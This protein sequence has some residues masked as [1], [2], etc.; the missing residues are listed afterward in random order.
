MTTTEEK[1]RITVDDLYRLELVQDPQISP[2]GAHIV[3]AQQWVQKKDEKKF[4]NLW[5]VASDGGEPRQYTSGDHRDS[6]PRWSPDGET[7]AFLSNREDEKQTQIYLIPF[8]GGEAR[9][10]TDLKGNIG[11]FSWSPDG[12]R[13]LLQF[14][15]KDAEALERE[16]DEQKKKLGIVARR[17][18]RADFRMDGEGYRPEERWHV[19]S[20]DVESG[21]ATQLT[22][23]EYDEHG[24]RWSPDGKE[25]AF[26]SNRSEQPDLTP[27]LD[28]VFVM[29]AEGGEPRRLPT[30]EGGKMGLRY[31]PDG[32]LLSYVGRDGTGNWWRHNQLWV[33]SADGAGEA[34]SLTDRETVHVSNSTIGDVADR[35]LTAP[36]WS[37]DGD[38]VY[39]QASEH[40]NTQLKFV[41]LEGQV[42]DVLA[43][44]GVFSNISLDADGRRLA[45]LYGTFEEPGQLW[46]SDAGG[47][48]RQQLTELNR[49]WL[50]EIEL[51]DVQSVWIKGVDGNDLQG[52]LLTPPGFDPARQYASVLEIHGG[53]WL[54]YG[55]IFMHEF[56]L[57]AAQDYVVHFCNPR[58][59]HGYGETHSKA[60]QEN[61][62][63]RD[64]ADVMAWTDY[65]ASLPYIDEERMGIAG[66]SYGGFMT[67]WTI[68]HT[69]RF[70]AAVAQRVV[71]NFVSFWG[72]SDVGLYFEEPWAGG[73]A[74]WEAI[75]IYWQQSPMKYIANV[76]TPTLI[77]HSEH[78]MRCNPEQ[79][80]QAFLAL[81]RLGVDTELILF[82]DESHG[83][84]RGGRTDRRVARLEHILRWFGKHL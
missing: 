81:R 3:Y 47:R 54:Q 16:E 34:R 60:I 21:E 62:G 58:G 65:V 72:S 84:S 51:G 82:P 61:W 43:D 35:P 22:S 73:C 71:S 31:S 15:K 25:I 78:D 11:G 44:H 79:G 29:P 42:R 56:Y 5:V 64:Y 69:Q 80:T 75:D 6:S 26:I 49:D 53:P 76:T 41:S 32:N 18:T 4:A 7:I 38:G 55:H 37:P 40:G 24:P 14:R 66:G 39:F 2:D 27:E 10:L 74:P 59:G 13:L 12:T 30:N 20:V 46:C 9:K 1:R 28:D 57:L 67:L 45:F 17:I 68:G 83:L 33:V 52:W 36:F 63:D 70:A 19:W 48:D 77:I 50:D 23:G 8:R